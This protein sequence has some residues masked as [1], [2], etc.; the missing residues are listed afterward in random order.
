LTEAQKLKK[1]NGR[2]AKSRLAPF[3]R[4]TVSRSLP[5]RVGISNKEGR[6]DK[7]RF[8]DRKRKKNWGSDGAVEE[9]GTQIMK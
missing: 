3:W 5:K 8:S 1:G 7:N 4:L 9:E 2:A 6:K